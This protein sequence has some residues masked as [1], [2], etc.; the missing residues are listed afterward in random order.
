MI[1]RIGQIA[2]LSVAAVT[3][4]GCAT[5]YPEYLAALRSDAMASAAIQGAEI[6]DRFEQ[7]ASIGGVLGKPVHAQ[8]QLSYSIEPDADPKVAKDEAVEEASV[9]GWTINDPTA[10]VVRGT[11]GIAGGEAA[12]AIYFADPRRLIVRL[13]HEFDPPR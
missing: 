10:D 11:K 12:I 3:V 4:T 7:D 5:V 1:R 2:V 6:E 9:S 8:I 13:E